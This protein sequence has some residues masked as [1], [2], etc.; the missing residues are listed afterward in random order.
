MVGDNVNIG[1]CTIFPSD[2]Y[3]L[4]VFFSKWIETGDRVEHLVDLMP[5]VDSV[6]DEPFR[7]G[8]LEPMGEFWDKFSHLR[9]ICPEED[10]DLRA[11]CSII[12][13]AANAEVENEGQRLA[14]FAAHS[15]YLKKYG[16]YIEVAG[17]CD[18]ADKQQEAQRRKDAVSGL[19]GQH[20]EKQ[21]SASGDGSLSAESINRVIK[22]LT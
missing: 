6:V 5:T 3:I 14:A 15:T 11:A 4:P 7:K 8:Y 16:E 13:T 2:R 10:D 9:G 22:L 17:I 20:I 21:F 19:L 18:E 1:F 12:Y